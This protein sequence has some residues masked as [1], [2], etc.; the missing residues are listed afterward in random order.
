[1]LEAIAGRRLV[2]HGVADLLQRIALL[3]MGVRGGQEQT[4][5]QGGQAAGQRTTARRRDE[6]LHQRR[7]ERPRAAGSQGTAV[8]LKRE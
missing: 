8:Y 5:H 2:E 6:M 4:H 3:C 7:Q 1:M